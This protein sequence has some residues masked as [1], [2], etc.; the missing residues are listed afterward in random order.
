MEHVRQ[1]SDLDLKVKHTNFIKYGLRV[2]SQFRLEGFE[3]GSRMEEK[4]LGKTEI[5]VISN[6]GSKDSGY[7]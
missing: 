1:T 4:L 2:N 5:G 3:S 6:S 7:N